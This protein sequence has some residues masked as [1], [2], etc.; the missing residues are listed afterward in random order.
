MTIYHEAR[1]ILW[2]I[3]TLLHNTRAGLIE[4][5]SGEPYGNSYCLAKPKIP[6]SERIKT[7]Q[8]LENA[9]DEELTK[10]FRFVIDLSKA[11]KKMSNFAAPLPKPRSISLKPHS[12]LLH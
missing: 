12:N 3:S 2:V 1:Y 10:Q 9:T 8:D 11:S 4:I 7:I 6:I 5:G